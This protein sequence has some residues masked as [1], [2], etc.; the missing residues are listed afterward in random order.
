MI[1]KFGFYLLREWTPKKHWA[2]EFSFCFKGEISKK[3]RKRKKKRK[4][5][6]EKRN[7]LKKKPK[8]NNK[9]NRC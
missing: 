4:N 7:K 2:S 8:N 3:K 9:L 6:K 5:N 1:P